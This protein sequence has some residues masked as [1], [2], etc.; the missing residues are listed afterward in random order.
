MLSVWKKTFIPPYP[1]P[2]PI[3][4]IALHSLVSYVVCL[5]LKQSML[6]IKMGPANHEDKIYSKASLKGRLYDADYLTI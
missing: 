3:I 2:P 4:I 1:I 5:F 6:E